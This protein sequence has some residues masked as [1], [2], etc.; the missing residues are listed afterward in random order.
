M[1][2]FAAIAPH[3]DLDLDPAL[4]PAMEELGRRCA[5]A[6]PEVALVVYRVA[7]EALTNVIRHA[8]ARR[9][10]VTLEADGPWLRLSVHDDGR[11]M[12]AV[13]SAEG[14][15]GIVGMRERAMLIGGTLKLE[16]EPGKGTTVTLEIP[17]GA[18]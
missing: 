15:T 13:N 3:G 4:R 2:C 11:G 9:A 17:L 16:S 8:D 12:S 5:A 6:A 14:S 18:P 7:Q 10:E 1:I